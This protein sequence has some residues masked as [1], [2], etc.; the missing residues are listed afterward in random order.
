LSL[1]KELLVPGSG[2]FFLFAVTLGVCLL[3][4]KKDGGRAGRHVLSAVVALYW[5]WSTP[6]LASQFVNLL[7]PDY[8]PVQ[9]RAQAGGADAI[10]VLGA[11]MDVFRSRGDTFEVSSREDALRIMEAARVYRALEQPWVVVTGGLP[12]GRE[13]EAARMADELKALGVPADRI[14]IEPRAQNT[15]EHALYVPP[16]LRERHA[17]RFVLVTSRQHIS[18][19]LRVFRKAGWD[20]VPST[21]E[22]YADRSDPIGRFL[23][24]KNALL[25]SEQV[26]YGE[27][28]LVYYWLRG[29]I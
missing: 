3:Y 9:S 12:G 15:H 18:R 1:F 6:V 23:P 21:P 29:W 27:G 24:S 11:G 8:P 13:T 17:T 19:A 5:I 7:T 28:A 16:L 2:S 25:A 26:L 22:A 20:P 10:V 14:V 4:R